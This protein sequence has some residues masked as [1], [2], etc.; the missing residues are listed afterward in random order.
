MT[1]P[2]FALLLAIITAVALVAVRGDY[3]A[4]AVVAAVGGLLAVQL[5][6][7]GFSK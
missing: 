7:S 2:R 3:E 6:W 5:W 4:A 1:I